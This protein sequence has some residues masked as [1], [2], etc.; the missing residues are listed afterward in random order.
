MSYNP[1]KP[2]HSHACHAF[3]KAG[4]RLVLDLDLAPGN[5]PR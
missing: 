4:T 2:G 3:L 5:G 1:R